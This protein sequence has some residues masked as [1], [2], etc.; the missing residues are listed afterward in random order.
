MSRVAL[1]RIKSLTF[2]NDAVTASRRSDPIPQLNCIGKPCE[3][4]T[5]EVVRCVNIGGEGLDVE[6]KVR[7]R[8]TSRHPANADRKPSAKQ[9]S[10][11]H[12]ALD[13]WKCHVK[14]GMVLEIHMC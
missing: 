11:R 10:P 13:A 5:P 14:A 6:W 3:L 2:Y 9:I 8:N 7:N 12:C 4:Y 1:A